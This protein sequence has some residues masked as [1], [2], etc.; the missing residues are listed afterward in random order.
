MT[1]RQRLLDALGPL[2]YDIF[3]QGSLAPDQ[4]T[5]AT[6][7]TYFLIEDED[8]SFYDNQATLSFP[9]IQL[10][11]YSTSMNVLNTLPEQVTPLIKAAGFVRDNRGRDLGMENGLYGWMM[12]LLTTERSRT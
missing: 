2:G 1:L 5:P 4:P 10:C 7:I 8:R 3:L 6:F 9:R 12:V 11:F